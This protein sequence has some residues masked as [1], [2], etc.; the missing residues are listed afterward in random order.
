MQKQGGNKLHLSALNQKQKKTQ[1]S[2]SSVSPLLHTSW[3]KIN[4]MAINKKN[5]HSEEKTDFPHIIDLAFTFLFTS[6]L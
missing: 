1:E 6:S 2:T 3:R 5:W 4:Q